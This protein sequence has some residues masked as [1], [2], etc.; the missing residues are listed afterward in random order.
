MTD[1]NIDTA[2]LAKRLNAAR[3][4]RDDSVYGTRSTRW[5]H[6]SPSDVSLAATIIAA[7]SPLQET[8]NEPND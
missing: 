3:C 7:L 2:A 5:H 1:V 6:L 4:L 8:P